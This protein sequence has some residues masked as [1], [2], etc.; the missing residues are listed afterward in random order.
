MSLANK[1]LTCF[2]EV[3]HAVYFGVILCL[4]GPQEPDFTAAGPMGLIW[5]LQINEVCD[6]ALET[7]PF[8]LQLKGKSHR[9]G[10]SEAQPAPTFPVVEWISGQTP[11]VFT[12]LTQP[13]KSNQCLFP[14]CFHWS[15]L[16]VWVWLITTMRSVYKILDFMS[17]FYKFHP[18]FLL[19]SY[20]AVLCN[21]QG[22]TRYQH[23]HLYPFG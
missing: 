11:A 22:L 9:W 13:S 4:P 16:C 23:I 19:S 17:I 10:R 20:T 18:D 3:S 1:E 7:F 8:L 14:L 21:K 12:V 15:C 2:K 6:T 5:P